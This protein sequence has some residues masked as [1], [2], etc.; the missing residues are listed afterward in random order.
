MIVSTPKCIYKIFGNVQFK[1]N[2]QLLDVIFTLING[3]IGISCIYLFIPFFFFKRSETFVFGILNY[4]LM[5]N[6]LNFGFLIFTLF[7]HCTCKK[8]QKVEKKKIKIFTKIRL[9]VEVRNSMEVWIVT[10]EQKKN[11][12]NA[13]CTGKRIFFLCWRILYEWKPIFIIHQLDK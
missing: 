7:L 5:W 1:E 3:E 13:L 9:L 10:K 6:Y 4:L 2:T 12:H 8:V 11:K